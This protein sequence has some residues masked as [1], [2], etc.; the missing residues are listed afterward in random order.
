MSKKIEVIIQ[1][2]ILVVVGVCDVPHDRNPLLSDP[3]Y[4][5][6][7]TP[8]PAVNHEDDL[9]FLFDAHFCGGG[10]VVNLIDD[11]DVYNWPL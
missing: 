10:F 4:L 8:A 9:A 6:T 11:L 1:S 3:T 5:M 2:V 7:K